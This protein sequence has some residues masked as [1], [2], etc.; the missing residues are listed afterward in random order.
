MALE[1]TTLYRCPKCIAPLPRVPGPS[2]PETVLDPDRNQCRR[3]GNIFTASQALCDDYAKK[4]RASS[5]ASGSTTPETGDTR[6]KAGKSP[7]QGAL[8]SR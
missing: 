6:P 2:G 8:F 1:G 5:R 7:R 3:C 4:G